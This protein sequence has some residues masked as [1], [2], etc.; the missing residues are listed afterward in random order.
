MNLSKLS[1]SIGVNLSEMQRGLSQARR[2]L[3]DFGEKASRIG[4]S[5][6]IAVTAPIVAFA[7]VSVRAFS[8]FDD[9]MTQ[10]TAIMSDVTKEMRSEMEETARTIS[11]ELAVSSTEA[12]NAYFFLAS[13]G[14]DAKQSI[15]ALPQVAKFAQAGMFDMSRATDLATDA[16]SA[17]GL[18]VKDATEN[19]ANLT[20]VTDV[21]VKANTIANAS[22]EQFGDA[23]TTRA[24]SALRLVNKSMEEGVAV[25]AVFADQGVKGAEA[26]TRLD[27]VLR[28]LQNAS[29]KNREA[30]NRLG[31]SV[32]D[33]S[34]KMKNMAD[35]ISDMEGAFKGMSDEQLRGTLSMLGF[36]DRSISATASLLGFSESIRNYESELRKAGGTT[37]L[38]ASKQMESFKNQVQLTRN[39]LTNMSQRIGE[40]V[41]EALLPMIRYVKDLAESLATIDKELLKNYIMWGAVVAA[42]GPVL[43]IFGQLIK[44]VSM[45]S[46]AFSAISLPVLGLIAVIALVATTIITNW[47]SIHRYFTTGNGATMWADF[48]G[49][50]RSTTEIIEKIWN[51]F[52]D[53]LIQSTKNVFGVILKIAEVSLAGINTL[54]Q[55]FNGDFSTELDIFRDNW[56]TTLQKIDAVVVKW[57]GNIIRYILRGATQISDFIVGHLVAAARALGS[58]FTFITGISLGKT[59]QEVN[60]LELALQSTLAVCEDLST[61]L[62]GLGDLTELSDLSE[63]VSATK[64]TIGDLT[65]EIDELTN[66][67]SSV[68]L[69]D[70]D[71]LGQITNK[72]EALE[73]KLRVFR[74]ELLVPLRIDI[75]PIIDKTQNL[76]A[77]LDDFRYTEFIDPRSIKAMQMQIAVLRSHIEHSF[78]PNV[79]KNFQAEIDILNGKIDRL[80]GTTSKYG[81]AVFI[82]N[83]ITNTFVNSFGAGMANIVVQ[84]EKLVDVLKNIGKL[85]LS[86][87]IQTGI[88]LLLSGGLSGGGFFGSLASGGGGGLFGK[89]FG[90]VTTAG[91][92]LIKDNGDIVK[93]HPD[94]NILAMKDFSKLPKVMGMES[95]QSVTSNVNSTMVTDRSSVSNVSNVNNIDR[96]SVSSVDRSAV[97]NIDRS[98]VSNID[99]SAVSNID[100]SAVS[101]I[102]RSA[103]SNID[104]SHSGDQINNS[105]H[106][107]IQ[108]INL[109]ELSNKLT[110][111]IASMFSDLSNS[112]A[113]ISLDSGISNNSYYNYNDS[114]M[115]NFETINSMSQSNNGGTVRVKLET[116]PVKIS[117]RDVTFAFV[118]GQTQWER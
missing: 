61:Q 92:A 5:M 74:G 6:S 96:S 115:N 25:L 14:L 89:L 112:L 65:N 82:L 24:G 90:K 21:L 12:A 87:A 54:M 109:S 117:N 31:I 81:A 58:V 17:L 23:L 51:A 3:Q 34:G 55:K 75:D 39:A 59:E 77:I 44:V 93:F 40:V 41:S 4:R 62:S 73:T 7:G 1:V 104:R 84:G 29:L 37:E 107:Q 45:V 70:F 49:I 69:G 102:D 113:S 114:T 30:F 11:R 101:N 57:T 67:L 97:S 9:A 72:I 13:A 76:R 94:D 56:T 43:L 78:D 18:T 48:T 15:A 38:V 86:S 46:V 22:V 95:G 110:L 53:S 105:E 66:S 16:Q 36:T 88:K 106:N 42:I 118:Q 20:R 85:L 33:S 83:D 108:P 2:S 27:I 111:G 63:V 28:D 100:R 52:G 60:N 99:R 19:L 98:A 8:D 35:I 64:K 26:G 80:T 10:S 50:I 71:K 32:F 103:V 91:D 79:I 116:T 47:Q 68:E